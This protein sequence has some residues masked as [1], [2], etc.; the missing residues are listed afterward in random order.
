MELYYKNNIEK[1]M[2]MRAV[3]RSRETGVNCD[4]DISDIIVPD[5]CPVF[6]VPMIRKTRYAA[7]LD[8]INPKLGYVK[9][10]VQVISK[11]ANV[12][13]Q[14]SSKEELRLFAEWVISQS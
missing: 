3:R 1:Q 8:K 12:M 7:S 13:K 5:I 10:N 11:L 6:K 14:D 9:G 4:L 2:L